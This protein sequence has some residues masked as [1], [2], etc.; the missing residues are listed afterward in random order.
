MQALQ[1]G[2]NGV[3]TA[4]QP[5]RWRSWRDCG[6]SMSGR[7]QSWQ[8]GP[9]DSQPV[10][11]QQQGHSRKRERI[12]SHLTSR[13]EEKRAQ[14]PSC[15]RATAA[16]RQAICR[17]HSSHPFAPPP[18]TLPGTP[19]PPLA[20]PPAD[21]SP[22]ARSGSARKRRCRRIPNPLRLL[23]RA[24]PETRIETWFAPGSG[25]G[26]RDLRAGT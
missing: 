8:T 5:T 26:D 18:R 4:V 7:A 21:Q 6:E 23:R 3:W 11:N 10:R 24:T 9:D 1:A 16:F 13:R 12:V 22:V 20:R 2:Q 19:A 25:Q 14:R 15:A 17:H